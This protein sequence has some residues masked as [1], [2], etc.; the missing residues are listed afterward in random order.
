MKSL[1][2]L[3]VAATM[4]L[5]LGGVAHADG[6]YVRRS[7]YQEYHYGPRSY[8]SYDRDVYR[9]GYAPRSRGYYSY[10]NRHYGQRVIYFNFF[11]LP[12]VT[13]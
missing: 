3:S 4:L 1:F 13:Y 6:R 9:H 7:G 11:G 12:V 10:G 5:T 8:R 2:L